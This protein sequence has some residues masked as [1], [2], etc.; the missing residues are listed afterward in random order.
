MLLTQYRSE[1][2]DS[3]IVCVRV[4][5]CVYVCV[6]V[7]ACVCI[8]HTNFHTLHVTVHQMGACV[9]ALLVCVLASGMERSG[10][11]FVL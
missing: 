4:C 3:V 5:V 8:F 11:I 10:I 7:R 6:C 9:L 2:A 1:L